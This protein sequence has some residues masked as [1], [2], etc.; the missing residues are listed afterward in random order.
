[1]TE[2]AQKIITLCESEYGD[3]P[4]IVRPLLIT[5][6]PRMV[7]DR[8]EFIIDPPGRCPDFGFV[9]ADGSFLDIPKDSVEIKPAADGFGHVLFTHGFDSASYVA[10]EVV[11]SGLACNRRLACLQFDHEQGDWLVIYNS[12]ERGLSLLAG[13]A[14]MGM[15][16][17]SVFFRCLKALLES[18]Y[19]GTESI[20]SSSALHQSDLDDI[21]VLLERFQLQLTSH[22]LKRTFSFWSIQEKSLHLQE[23][24]VVVDALQ[25]LTPDCCLFGGIALG[26]E[27]EGELL[28]HD[29]DIDILICLD[30]DSY[31]NLSIALDAVTSALETAGI[32]V[33]GRFFNHLWVQSLGHSGKTLDVFVGLIEGDRISCYPIE[34][35]R[36]K[37][38]LMFPAREHVLHGVLLP[39]PKDIVHYL[40]AEYG[41]NWFTPDSSFTHVWDRLPYADIAGPLKPGAMW[42][43]GEVAFLK[44]QH[45]KTAP[46]KPTL[47]TKTAED[48]I[49]KQ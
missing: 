22:G 6:D 44:R 1:M 13:A 36:L 46:E 17:D 29:D 38:D 25:A 15:A 30:I 45:E 16:A 31:S 41:A 2:I 11:Q 24:R 49:C 33:L 23:A 14:Q 47:N 34:R 4:W 48:I 5:V 43:R 26:Y 27:R 9:R 10:L 35:K 19:K 39:F 3:L 7:S 21:S 8:F 40:S 32:Q 42:T 12:L 20:L 28:G 18:D 37:R